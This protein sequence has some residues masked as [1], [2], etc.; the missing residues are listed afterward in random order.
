MDVQMNKKRGQINEMNIQLQV[1]L[2]VQGDSQDKSSLP[3]PVF[4]KKVKHENIFSHNWLNI[5]S[6]AAKCFI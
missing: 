2:H 5:I 3:K 6:D 1:M 4:R